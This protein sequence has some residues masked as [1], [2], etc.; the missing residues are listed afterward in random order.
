MAPYTSSVMQN[1][2]VSGRNIIAQEIHF[3][4]YEFV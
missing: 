3:L 2:A 1:T 4:T